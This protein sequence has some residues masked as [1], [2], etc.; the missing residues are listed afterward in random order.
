MKL[1]IIQIKKSVD[2]TIPMRVHSNDACV[3][4]TADITEKVILYTDEQRLI[5]TGIRVNI[6]V[7]PEEFNWVLELMPRSGN[8]HKHGI[9]IMNSPAQIDEGYHGNI[10]VILKNTKEKPFVINP[11]DRIA[12]MKL[13]KSYNFAWLEVASF[14]S[15]TARG[16]KGIGSSG[17]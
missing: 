1:P 12:Q 10:M 3:D 13:T 9:T 15:I 6:P 17:A 11:G 7:S 4:L 2:A 5:D 14:T 16:V 8:A